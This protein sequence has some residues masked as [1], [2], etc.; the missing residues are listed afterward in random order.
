MNTTFKA[1][2]LTAAVIVLAS[3]SMAI[4]A[5]AELTA[6]ANHDHITIDSF[7]HGSEVSVR[8]IC[9]PDVELVV[10]ITSPEAHQTLKQKGKVGGF[11]WMNVGTLKIE[12]TPN[13]YMLRAT[14]DMGKL[15][16]SDESEKYIIGYPALSK[17]AELSPVADG[18]EKDKW[19]GEYVKFK[20][21]SKLFESTDGGFTFGDSGGKHTYYMKFAWPYQAPPGDYLV[22]VYAVKGGKVVEQA[23][24]K[25]QVE[26]VGVVKYLAGMAKNNGA[27]Y[28]IFSIL[29]ALGAGF[30]VGLVFKKGGGAH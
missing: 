16:A 25:V 13:L 9:D 29:A 11:L 2:V 1:I 6:K 5:S 4:E 19:F 3:F 17:H 7:Y 24:S 26:Q 20:E 21:N 12:N 8:G 30:G 28:G 23:T 15:M 14:K 27:L 18:S 10:K 22:T